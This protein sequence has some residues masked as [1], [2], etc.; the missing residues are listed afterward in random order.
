MISDRPLATGERGAALFTT[1]L[2]MLVL[3]GLAVGIGVFSHNSM[4]TGASQLQ[5]K[6]TFYIAEAGWQR[7]RQALSAGT[8]SADGTSHTE[9]PFGAGAGEY[10]VT[11]VNN[12]DGTYTITSDGYVPSQAV[13]VARRRIV[14][15][16]MPVNDT[17]TN[18]SRTGGTTATASSSQPGAGNT[19]AR[20]IDNDN[21]TRWSAGTRGSGSWL[22]INLTGQRA[23]ERILIDERENIA[24]LTIEMSADG[25]AWA[26]IPG[27]SC[28]E[29]PAGSQPA[30]WTCTFPAVRER[31]FRV[32][33]TSVP[34]GQR[35][36]VEEFES[37]APQYGFGSV[38]TQW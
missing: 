17:T 18:Q 7:A 20:A 25:S 38:R 30:T 31:Y 34:A 15:A 1:F 32:R 2:M 37:Y 13:A 36:R 11:I 9:Q 19:P 12:G 27:L 21:E 10:V 6:R 24:A 26:S 5:D 33:C 28:S 16:S 23:I 3:S 29:A 4:V 35:A 14:E 8:W 22:A